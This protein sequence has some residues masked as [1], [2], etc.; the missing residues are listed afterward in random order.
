MIAILGDCAQR[1]SSG[2]FVLKNKGRRER[3]QSKDE[4]GSSSPLGNGLEGTDK[5]RNR[6]SKIVY[7]TKIASYPKH[8]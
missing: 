5:S 2:L 1:I 3:I 8:S 7:R 6:K 4:H